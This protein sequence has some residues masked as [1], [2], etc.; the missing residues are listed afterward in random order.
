M[1][2]E[3]APRFHAVGDIVLIRGEVTEMMGAYLKIKVVGPG[4][5]FAQYLWVARASL[6]VASNHEV[7]QPINGG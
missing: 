7:F 4:Q 6:A 3:H 5:G 2:T 1:A